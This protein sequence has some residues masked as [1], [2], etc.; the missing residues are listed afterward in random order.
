MNPLWPIW[1]WPFRLMLRDVWHRG[2]LATESPFAAALWAGLALVLVALVDLLLLELGRG[3][4]RKASLLFSWCEPL[5]LGALLLLLG[6]GLVGS[7][8]NVLLADAI[9]AASGYARVRLMTTVHAETLTILARQGGFAIAAVAAAA[10]VT[11]LA[12]QRRRGRDVSVGLTLLATVGFV[13][14]MLWFGCALRD[15][16][17]VTTV[18]EPYPF[19]EPESRLA[20]LVAARPR[21]TEAF[22]VSVALVLVAALVFWLAVNGRD[23]LLAGSRLARAVR[24]ASVAVG[25]FAVLVMTGY[26]EALA[27]ENRASIAT[28]YSF[29]NLTLSFSPAP[30]LPDGA[31][32][33]ATASRGTSIGPASEANDN[34]RG[35]NLSS[36][37]QAGAGI[38]VDPNLAPLRLREELSELRRAGTVLP[39]VGLSMTTLRRLDRP[40]LGIATGAHFS[41]ARL[42]LRASTAECAQVDGPAIDLSW[43]PFV[44]TRALL[45]AILASRRH[46]RTACLAVGDPICPEHSRER[47]ACLTRLEATPERRRATPPGQPLRAVRVGWGRA[48][49]D[50]VEVTDPDQIQV[51][52]RDRNRRRLGTLARL[53]REIENEGCTLYLAMNAGM[54]EPDFQ[55][56]GMLV[57]QGGLVKGW[58]DQDGE[59]NFFMKPNGALL[60]AKGYRAELRSS[61]DERPS[62]EGLNPWAQREL[63]WYDWFSPWSGATQSG[64]MLLVKGNEHPRFDPNSSNRTYRNGVG[65]RDGSVLFAI[66]NTPVTFHEMAVLFT[67]FGCKDALYLDGNVSAMDFPPFERKVPAVELGPMLAVTSCPKR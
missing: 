65:L 30:G 15:I 4:S 6:A 44:G 11:Y 14:A 8:W 18:E 5:L 63:G 47:R 29:A 27:R 66:S 19:S 25:L 7:A 53:R 40:I 13:A 51:R 57:A 9:A 58:N 60:L 62:D 67:A 35:R 33:D 64:P 42:Q 43:P 21:L 2:T 12:R 48:E 59:G 23:G 39:N 56:V 50:V 26:T 36:H 38:D 45:E 3:R 41:T 24:Y 31:G 1:V 10:S 49:F 34:G 54:F 55:P 61:F 46:R 16:L 32:P 28:D 20:R 52:Y 17:E 37:S 22:D